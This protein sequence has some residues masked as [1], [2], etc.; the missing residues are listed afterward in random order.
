MADKRDTNIDFMRILACLAVV[1]LHSF[2]ESQTVG[3]LIIYRLCGF[4]I[5]AFFVTSGY[6][7]AIKQNTVKAS[8]RR[9]KKVLI[10]IVLWNGLFWA[11][12]SMKSILNGGSIDLSELLKSIL[13]SFIQRGVFWHF[14][15]LAA[16]MLLY[17][18]LPV[19][20]EL[21]QDKLKPR[22]VR[23][24]VVALIVGVDLQALSEFVFHQSIQ[25]HVIQT[26]RL[27]T[28]LQY[29]LLGGMLRIYK[30][31]WHGRKKE[32]LI[33]L[34]LAAVS[35]QLWQWIMAKRIG[36]IYGEAFYD[37]I[38]TL[39]LVVSIIV[40]VLNLNMNDRFNSVVELIAPCTMGIY[41]VHP[42]I[43][44]YLKKVLFPDTFVKSAAV[45]VIL[46]SLSFLITLVMRKIPGL[47]RLV[48]L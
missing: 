20:S 33:A 44:R 21:I 1:G 22:I 47:R 41:V 37:S 13:R 2:Q 17:A 27:W 38:T 10:V 16:L 30:E 6:F 9:I 4:A 14:W 32:S 45:F 23:F 24:W 26:F 43:L 29:F 25:R 7:L 18:I 36:V 34:I 46:V 40:F 48:H 12:H 5:P 15:Y 42:L 8:I 35:M 31:S 28:W 11:A 19:L 39:F 3:N